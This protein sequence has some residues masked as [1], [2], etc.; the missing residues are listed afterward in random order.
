[1]AIIETIRRVAQ[2]AINAQTAPYVDV[3]QTQIIE[4]G[5]GEVNKFNFANYQYLGV[6]SVVWVDQNFDSY[7]TNGYA[8]NHFIYSIIDYIATKAAGLPFYVKEWKGGKGTRVDDHEV[9]DLLWRPNEMQGQSE[10]MHQ[11]YGYQLT[12]GNAF[13][14]GF[15]LDYG[16]NK[17]KAKELNVMPSQGTEII[18]GGWMKPVRGYKLIYG[19]QVVEFETSEVM[20]TKYPNLK[21]INGAELYGMSPIEA[22]AKVLTKSNSAISAQTWGYQNAGIAGV[23]YNKDGEFPWNSTQQD[24]VEQKFKQKFTGAQNNKRIMVTSGD[25][26]WQ[27][28]GLSPVDLDILEDNKVTKRDMCGVFKVPSVLFGD[29][30][31]STYNNMVEA[32]KAAWTDAI[33]PLA[34]KF[35]D[36]FNRWYMWPV[37]NQGG[38]KY[39]L[40][41]DTSGIEELQADK[42]TLAEVLEKA[43]YIKASRKQE[44]MGEE[45]DP[46]MDRYF[47]PS[48]LIPLDQLDKSYDAPFDGQF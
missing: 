14:Y 43:W 39:E 36:D 42:K 28:M 38:T 10:F 13:L 26:G 30:E 35:L 1:M 45:V 48:N 11:W 12:T 8:G 34:Y 6:G 15:K 22:L 2:S 19:N 20:H 23:L 24:I 3:V 41:V 4:R 33:L 9:V 21:W 18:S 7:I 47:V 25:V 17:G 37:Y 40:C 31:Q 46:A 16:P 5:G 44:I 29:T 32:R 27:Q